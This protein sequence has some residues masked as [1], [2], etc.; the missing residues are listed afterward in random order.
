MC[1]KKPILL[2]IKPAILLVLL[3]LLPADLSFA[4]GDDK[5]SVIEPPCF[6]VNSTDKAYW[7]DQFSTSLSF[8]ILRGRN[9]VA[10][11]FTKAMPEVT[12]NICNA[13]DRIAEREKTSLLNWY[14]QTLS[15]GY[16]YSRLQ[17]VWDKRWSPKLCGLVQKKIVE[18]N[19]PLFSKLPEDSEIS[20]Q[21]K[22]EDF[23]ASLI[24]TDWLETTGTRSTIVAT[25]EEM[26]TELNTIA[27][28]TNTR[29]NIEIPR[30]LKSTRDESIK[31]I[32]VCIAEEEAKLK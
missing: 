17:K 7:H 29:L 20:L 19:I 14:D 6:I 18:K 1:K 22:I 32:E 16:V 27:K 2:K 3:N 24:Q 21:E 23:L 31:A 25:L 5:N 9:A 4:A 15:K 12:G 28:E 8:D 30:R 10:A 11:A 13:V 26:K